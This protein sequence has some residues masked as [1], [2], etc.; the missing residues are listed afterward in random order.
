MYSAKTNVQ[1]L[2]SL[3]KQHGV[4]HAVLS[5]GS[6]NM[7]IVKSLE[8]DPFFTTYS[9]VD[10]RSAAYFA[11]GVSLANQEPTLISCTSAQATRNYL[12]GMTEAYYRGTPLV[13]VTADYPQEFI[14]QGNM[15]AIDQRSIPSDAAKVSVTLPLA[16]DSRSTRY[17]EQLVNQALLELVQNGPGPVHINI[18]IADHWDGGIPTLPE[19]AR[20]HRYQHLDRWPDLTH[21]RVMVLVGQ[22]NEFS[23][24]QRV[25]LEDFAR[26]TGAVVYV[27]RLSNYFGAQAVSGS[28][29][30]ENMDQRAFNSYKPDLLITIGGQH[31]DYGISDRLKAAEGFEHWRVAQDGRLEDTYG[32]LTAVFQTTEQEFF[33][34]YSARTDAPNPSRDF[35]ALW[36][37]G[38]AKRI[39]PTSLPLSHAL[40]AAT[41][42]D[43]IPEHSVVH[44][45]ILSSLRNWN[46]F[47]AREDVFGYSNV[48]AFGIDGCLSTFIGHAHATSRLCL[49]IIG[50]LAFFYDMNIVGVRSIPANA[51]VV[52]VNNGG[53]GE[54]RLYSHV[55]DSFGDEANEHIAAAGHF[56]SA[57]G[58]VESMGWRYLSARSAEELHQSTGEFLADSSRPVLLEVFTT[59]QDDSDG[60]RLI[61]EAN[62]LESLERRLARR[63]PPQVKKIARTVLG[64]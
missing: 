11:I 8:G 16:A 51:R 42:A 26:A 54:F 21:K 1:V 57:R 27:N 3:L 24:T 59:M 61:R 9:V 13:V 10:E 36:Q 47:A 41:F 46:F 60:V 63:L 30:V 5:P 55:A 6:R 4:R 44:F 45:G 23:E 56:G 34:H 2:V 62:T 64:R 48:A 58:W 19:Y 49:L 32:N 35:L 18:P 14:R 53:G 20:I 7:A 39:I 38:E 33:E 29:L 25:A 22:H 40:V 52:L 31:G 37:E 50:D 12:P 28:L 43:R 17:C 15:Q